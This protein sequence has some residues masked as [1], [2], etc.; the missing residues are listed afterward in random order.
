MEL[1]VTTY[2]ENAGR[3]KGSQDWA[4]GGSHLRS[5]RRETSKGKRTDGG[6]GAEK[7]ASV[8]KETGS[9]KTQ[10]EHWCSSAEDGVRATG[11]HSVRRKRHTWFWLEQ[12]AKWRA[13][14]AAY[15]K[16]PSA[17][18]RANGGQTNHWGTG[19]YNRRKP[20]RVVT[21]VTAKG[22]HT[23]PLGPKQRRQGTGLS[24]S[25]ISPD[26]RDFFKYLWHWLSSSP[27]IR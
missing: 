9:S 24:L 21:K 4:Q 15:G 1:D 18:F 17:Y 5:S 8:K 19:D 2:G 13:S 16:N 25:R 7:E 11:G 22:E 3:E 23:E 6:G 27:K 12:A 26:S 20:E 10:R 14:E